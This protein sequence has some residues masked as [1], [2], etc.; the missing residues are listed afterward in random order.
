MALIDVD[1]FKLINDNHG[2]LTG[3]AVLRDISRALGERLRG[4]DL[5]AR[6]GGEEFVVVMRRAGRE[7]AA[8]VIDAIRA[9]LSERAGTDDVPRYTFSAGVAEYSTDGRE[10]TALLGKADDRLYA[11]KD[12]GRNR[13]IA[14]D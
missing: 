3:D 12:G 1:Y 4:T 8:A 10:A 5:V 2:H 14:M 13:I 11:A 9:K 7:Q 6:Y